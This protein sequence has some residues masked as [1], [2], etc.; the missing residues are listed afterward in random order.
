M[1]D[2]AVFIL[3][4]GRPDNLKTFR[5]LERHGYTGAV[6]IIIDDQDETAEEYKKLYG[7][8][9]KQFNKDKYI[10]LTDEGDCSGDRRAPIFARNA[11]F[12]I[13]REIGIKYFIQL[14]D[15]YTN[16]SFRFD[17]TGVYNQHTTRSLNAIFRQL[18]SF[19]K[20]SPATSIAI[21]QGGDFIG[22]E[23]SAYARAIT[24][25][26]KAMNSFLC[27]TERQFKFAGKLNDDVNTY[28]TLGSRG[29][30]F[31]S[32]N[33]VSLTQAQTQQQEGGMTD[34]Y[35]AGGTYMKSFI[36]AMMHPSSVKIATMGNVDMRIHHSINWNRTVPKILRAV[37]KK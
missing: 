35:L 2:F 32:F 18:L 24:L 4:H 7:K 19:Y 27:S 1:K 16:F 9:V 3:S 33:Q 15:D 22:G 17:H 23:E 26:R 37:H 11:T 34:I 14:D 13:A 30:L 25:K 21:S 31:F 10:E 20:K 12:D 6:Y 28:V 29:K 36:T 5:A 8:K